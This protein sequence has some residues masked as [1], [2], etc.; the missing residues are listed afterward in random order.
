MN[1]ERPLEGLLRPPLE[2]YSTFTALIVSMFLVNYGEEFLLPISLQNITILFLLGFASLRFKNGYRIYRYQCNLKKMPNYTMSSKQL[3]ISKNRLFLGKGFHWTSLHTQRLRDLD[4]PYNLT[5]RYPSQ[6]YQSAR[7]FECYAESKKSLTFL[8]KLLAMDSCFNPFRPYPKIGGESCLH[9]ISEVE[10]NIF[11]DLIS[12][13]G[14]VLVL[15]TTGVGKTRF[16]EILIGQDI[17]RGDVVIVLD[18]KGDADLLKRVYI[19]ASL[20]GR[21]ADVL[22]LHLGFPEFSAR[23]NPIGSFTKITQVATRVTNGLPST[24]QAASFKEFAWKYV[25]LVAKAIVAMGVKPTYRLISFYITRLDQL[26][27]K[28]VETIFGKEDLHFEEMLKHYIR[29][30]TKE[31]KSGELKIPTCMEA[32]IVY[33]QNILLLRNQQSLQLITNDLLSDLFAACRIDKTY[34]DKITASVGPL[35]EKLTSGNVAE[36]LSPNYSD[37]EDTRPI[38]DWLQVIRQKKIVYIGMDALTDS[39]VSSAFGNAALS[40]LASIAGHLYNFGL[41]HGFNNLQAP[42]D[43][44][45]VNIHSDEFNEIIGDEFIP[46]LNKAR[47]AGFNVTA[48][49]QTWSDVLAR[50][51]STAKAGQVAGNLNTVILFRTKESETVERILSQLPKIPILRVTP[52]SSSNDTPLGGDGGY[53]QSSNSDHYAHSDVRLIEQ[54]DVL[55]LP[56]GQAFAVLEGGKTY[57]LRMPLPTAEHIQLPHSLTDLLQKMHEQEQLLK[58]V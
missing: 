23:Y 51:G 16:A 3:P 32:I 47:G 58:T 20:A 55:N 43:L 37:V 49:T 8:A 18:P 56:K 50:L 17:R 41:D 21:A 25:N 1:L 19:E 26:L 44:P 12:R 6:L 10:H 54:T 35:L 2:W 28:Y 45:R 24:G 36:I 27:V 13:A 34:Y 38:F 33:A 22:V 52:A 31:T 9:G 7:K 5:Y 29:E 4:L 14:H 53:Y 57:K 46:I 40:D 48:Y 39:A 11:V 15:G 42:S 30:N